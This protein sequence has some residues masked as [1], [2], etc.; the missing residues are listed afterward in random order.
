MLSSAFLRASS[1]FSLSLGNGRFISVGNT[2][3][4]NKREN[5]L[6]VDTASLYTSVLAPLVARF[7]N[8]LALFFSCF[9]YT[10]FYLLVKEPLVKC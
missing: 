2:K 10:M 6:Y 8:L 1:I 7:L 5:I 4:Q 3:L 9:P